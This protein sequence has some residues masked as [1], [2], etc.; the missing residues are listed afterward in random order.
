VSPFDL[1]RRDFLKTLPIAAASVGA[2]R[3]A[4]YRAADFRHPE[5]S[6]VA[7]LPADNYEMD[8]AGIVARGLRLLDVD[9]R[10]K[11][12][13]LK[14]NLVEY[15]ADKA[16]NTDPRVVA[17]AASA[18]L[19][20]GAREVLIGEGPGHRRDLEYLLEGT[21]MDYVLRDLRLKFVDLNHDDVRL[22]TL[23]SRFTR[24]ENL[25]LPAS[26]LDA[27]FIVSMPKLKTHHY[28]GLTAS[29]KN[30][31]GTVPGAVYGWPKN[32]LH[33]RGIEQSIVDLAATIQPALTIVDGIIGMEGD[34]PIMGRPRHLGLLA[35]GTD[36]PAVDATCA[37][38]IGL[39]PSK[40][41][42]LSVAGAFLGNIEEA[43]IDDVGE[44]LNRFRTQFDVIAPIQRIR[45]SGL[46]GTDSG[47]SPVV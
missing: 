45:L 32:L 13:F 40:M 47:L 17:A 30:L 41:P 6:A 26:L 4:P 39:D 43:R 7:L 11:R 23:K 29:M 33:F 9:V 12:V 24:L 28:A 8:L 16:I 25:W 37:R 19:S 36:L 31:F 20:G 38:V 34:G 10:G 27:D 2:C 3:R 21:G 14:P 42:Y 5:R 18:F 15:E 1:T 46:F 22:T 35:M 44:T